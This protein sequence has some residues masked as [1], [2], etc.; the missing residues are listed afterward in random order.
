MHCFHALRLTT[1]KGPAFALA[2]VLIPLHSE[3]PLVEFQSNKTSG[4]FD[5]LLHSAVLR[6]GTTPVSDPR[7]RSQFSIDLN[8]QSHRLD[9]GCGLKVIVSPDDP[10]VGTA[11]GTFRHDSAMGTVCRSP[12]PARLR[13]SISS[14]AAAF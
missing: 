2:L 9:N 14:A 13:S 11:A 7:E 1:V 8:R 10:I 6:F 5:L 4:G 3:T 12:T